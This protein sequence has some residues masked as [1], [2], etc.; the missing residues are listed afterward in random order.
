MCVLCLASF[1]VLCDDNVVVVPC[2]FSCHVTIIVLLNINTNCFFFFFW[3]RGMVQRMML[4]QK[5]YF[6][7]FLKKVFYFFFQNFKLKWVY[8]FIV[9]NMVLSFESSQKE[10]STQHAKGFAA[11]KFT[12]KVLLRTCAAKRK[13]KGTSVQG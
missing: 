5:T 13:K 6:L 9:S 10:K 2:C 11:F 3:V 8:K 1:V 7:K 12:R 4:F